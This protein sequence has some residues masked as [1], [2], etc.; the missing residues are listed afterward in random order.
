MN[1]QLLRTDSVNAIKPSLDNYDKNRVMRVATEAYTQA[2]TA[3]KLTDSEAEKML[4]VDHRDWMQIKNGK[5]KGSLNE[6]QLMR[7][8]AVIAIHDALHSCFGEEMANRWATAPN[9]LPMFH[10]RKPVDAMIEEGIP[11][12]KKAQRLTSELLGGM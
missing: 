3:W 2:V 10:G 11:M 1:R 9:R 7:I 12:M 5:W 8:G 4:A 6:E